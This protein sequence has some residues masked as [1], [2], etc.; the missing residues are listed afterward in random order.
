[1]VT[2]VREAEW[3][4]VGAV[5]PGLIDGLDVVAESS[6]AHSTRIDLFGVHVDQVTLDTAMARVSGFLNDGLPHQ[7]VT[8]NLDFLYL[9]D[10][11]LEF[12]ATINEADLVVPDGMP[13]VWLSRLLGSPLRGRV[14]GVEL[15]DA[16]C[17]IAAETGARVFF[18]GG[19]PQ[20]SV[21]AAERARE[22]YAG[23]AVTAYAPP[24]GPISPE[25]DE[26][27]VA[28]ILEAKPSF[29]FVA[30]G[31][32]RQDRWIRAHRDRLGVPVA[33]GVGCVLDLLAGTVRRAPEWMRSSGFE[34]SYRLVQEPGRLWR[35][36]LIDD[37]PLLGRLC[38]MALSPGRN[39]R[40]P[41]HLQRDGGP[42]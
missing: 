4:P 14:T 9:A 29:L 6:I 17:R 15:V 19:R 41:A 24:Y 23:L 33:M 40:P 32:P 37:L 22:Q 10:R 35:R 18:L 26:R 39:L 21:A 16:S 1:M 13:V 5:A 27:I 36:Y 25:E 12:R 7:I 11:D 38:F 42:A 20:V 30:L 3:P 2:E 8:V 31:A 28:M 34:W